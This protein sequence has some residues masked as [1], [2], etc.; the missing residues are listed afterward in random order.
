MND[1]WEKIDAQ[2]A[3]NLYGGATVSYK[4]KIFY[5]AVCG[6]YVTLTKQSGDRVAYFKHSTLDLNKD[7][8]D[9][10]QSY[11]LSDNFQKNSH[12][13][14][15]KLL[16]IDNKVSFN[17][18]FPPIP[19][20]LQNHIGPFKVKVKN[21]IEGR[22]YKYSNERFN[23]SKTTYVNVGQSL[24]EKYD[25][26]V[27]TQSSILKS[28]WELRDT[29]YAQ[30]YTLF[31]KT[32]GKKLPKDADVEIYHHYY[33]VVKGQ[34]PHKVSG[35]ECKQIMVKS[36]HYLS[37][38]EVWAEE[39]TAHTSRFFIDMGYRLTKYPARLFPVWPVFVEQP[40]NIFYLGKK[41]VFYVSG[42]VKLY[43]INLKTNRSI[44]CNEGTNKG[45]LIQLSAK[46]NE[47]LAYIGRNN[48]LKYTYFMSSS[49]NDLENDKMNMV[50]ED[51]LQNPIAEGKYDKLP[52]NK[53]LIVIVPF[54]GVVKRYRG[55][56]REYIRLKAN[57]EKEI[58]NLVFGE[59]IRIYIGNDCQSIISYNLPNQNNDAKLY[60]ELIRYHDQTIALPHNILAIAKYFEGY[61]KTKEFL[62]LCLK[63]RAISLNAMKKLAKVIENGG[64]TNE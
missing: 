13:L 42:N 54:D 34:R 27:E 11:G 33:L 4:N 23:L 36:S 38:F 50:V 45:S 37:L 3:S 10:S 30:T 6:N 32:T 48:V 12:N 46:S 26:E 47:H 52:H 58:D 5:C 53:K 21:P 51:D 7:C 62:Q 59:E 9:R 16:I 39:F 60:K 55:K 63:K 15:L 31:D 64:I 22:T 18:G 61:P 41:I 40:Y 8:E 19:L 20:E 56:K 49:L 29:L 25:V 57:E 43:D 17:L 14:P 1:H 44:Q 2:K 35:I 24:S 28:R